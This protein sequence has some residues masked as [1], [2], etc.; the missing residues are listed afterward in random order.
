PARLSVPARRRSG[1]VVRRR[2]EAHR[3]SRASVRAGRRGHRGLRGADRTRRGGD[4]RGA[5]DLDVACDIRQRSRRRETFPPQRIDRGS[6]MIDFGKLLTLQGPIVWLPCTI[7][8]YA[9]CS[10]I[11]QRTNKAPL[12]NPTLLTI[13]AVS[14]VLVC[15]GTSYKAYFESV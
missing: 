6:Q 5:D 9:A 11:Y 7:V 12:A 10:A 4:R 2:I 8:L 13:A 15:T 1:G 14:V 3:Q